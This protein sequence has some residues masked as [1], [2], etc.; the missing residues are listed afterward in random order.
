MTPRF[1]KSDEM[2]VRDLVAAFR[3]IA[4]FT[5]IVTVAVGVAAFLFATIT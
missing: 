3:F 1:L 5:V 4:L 2:I